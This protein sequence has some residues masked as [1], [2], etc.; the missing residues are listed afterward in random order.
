M[1]RALATMACCCIGLGLLS[2]PAPAQN[3]P[4][5]TE[6]AIYAGLHEA[7]AK[8]DVAEIEKLIAEAR[9]QTFRIPRAARRF[10]SP[11]I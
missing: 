6:I 8:G 4:T 3:A 11:S 2:L 1:T 5:R 9:S 10:T 7:A